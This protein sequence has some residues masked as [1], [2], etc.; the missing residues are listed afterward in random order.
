MDH[1]DIR[2]KILASV[3]TLSCLTA[4]LGLI[5]RDHPEEILIQMIQFH[6][7][8]NRYE[9]AIKEV[10]PKLEILKNDCG[11]PLIRYCIMMIQT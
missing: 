10:Y 11:L 6:D 5:F 2:K 8:V 4:V 3:I 7:L 9:S 1:R